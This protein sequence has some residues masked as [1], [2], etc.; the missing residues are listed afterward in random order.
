MF[1]FK[2][3]YQALIYKHLKKRHNYTAILASETALLLLLLVGPAETPPIA[4]Q[5]SRPFVPLTTF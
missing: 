3:H 4:L 1:L 2:H 5:P